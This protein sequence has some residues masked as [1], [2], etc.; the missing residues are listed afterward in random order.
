MVEIEARRLVEQV[1]LDRLKSPAQ[2]NRLGQFATPPPLALDLASYAAALWRERSDRV[3]FLDPAIGTGSFYS[4]IRRVFPSTSI[5]DACGVELDPTFAR[6]AADLWG[7]AGL[8]VIPGDFT[9]LAP[10]LP[11]NLVL[12]NPPY[13]R[14]HHLPPEEKDRLKAVVSDRLGIAISGLAGLYAHFLLLGDAWLADGGLAIWLIPSEFMDVNYGSVLKSYLTRRVTLR[15]IHR[16]CPSDCAIRRRDGDLG[17]RRLRQDT[18]ARASRG[19]HVVRRADLPTH[20]R[21]ARPPVEARLRQEVDGI[22]RQ[23]ASDRPRPSRRSAT[24]SRS[25]GDWPRGPMP[26]SSSSGRKRVVA[27]SQTRSSGRSCPARATSGRA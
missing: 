22:P 17:H 18:A 21:G 20:E 27:A 10:D 4:A 26:S 15:H 6:A 14:H 5:A 8:R 2:R 16:Y 11:Y 9:R 7:G 19:P 23:R 13:V 12:A 25:S 24:S 1:R 3:R